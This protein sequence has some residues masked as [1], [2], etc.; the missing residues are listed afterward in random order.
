MSGRLETISWRICHCA[1]E[2]G[3]GEGRGAGGW[4]G[5]RVRS[6]ERRKWVEWQGGGRERLSCRRKKAERNRKRERNWT[7]GFGTGGRIVHSPST[8]SSTRCERKHS[9]N[10][11]TTRIYLKAW[12]FLFSIHPSIHRGTH[13]QTLTAHTFVPMGLLPEN[14]SARLQFSWMC[15][16]GCTM[17]T[18]AS[19]RQ[20]N[21]YRSE[22]G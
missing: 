9:L 12:H 17:H 6:K 15:I 20:A 1:G 3:S 10:S 18:A 16:N 22:G 5:R 21:V 13:A 2:M 7:C 19:I 8:K 11:N 14:I 4:G